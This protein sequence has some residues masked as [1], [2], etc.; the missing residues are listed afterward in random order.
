MQSLCQGLKRE[1]LNFIWKWVWRNCVNWII[2]DPAAIGNYSK[3]HKP[4]NIEENDTI[5]SQLRKGQNKHDLDA[6]EICKSLRLHKCDFVA[7]NGAA[8]V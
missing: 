6:R 2:V 1:E 7:K 4:I 8:M 5:Q 3:N